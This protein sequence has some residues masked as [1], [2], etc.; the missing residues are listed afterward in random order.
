MKK[1][2]Q[3]DQVLLFALAL[4]L[5]VGGLA[6]SLFPAARFSEKENR[7][8]A[9]FPALTTA[10]LADGSYTAALDTYAAERFPGRLTLRGARALYQ[11]SQGRYEVGGVLLC[12]D[13]S[14]CKRMTVNER[15][16]GQN[17]S[18]LQKLCN[19]YGEKLTIAIAPRRIDARTEVLPALYDQSENSGAWEGLSTALPDAVTFPNLTADAHWYRTDHHWSTAGAYA[20]YCAL[21][22]HLGYT[23]YSKESFTI[24]TVSESFSGTSDAAA[25]IPFIA[26]DHIELYRY[27]GDAD[28]TVRKGKNP[29]PFTGFYD[30]ERLATRDQYSVFLGGNCGVLE[31]TEASD[32]PTLLVIKDS[33]ANALLPFLARHF[34]I[35]AVD[36]RYT[37][38]DIEAYAENAD[39]VLVLCNMQTITESAV[40][41]TLISE[42]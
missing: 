24:E 41:K 23:P 29:A 27:E 4:F 32:R 31:I 38:E 7:N 33:F 21:G 36:P 15:A 10:G 40:F 16:Y 25:G 8:L 42:H 2:H 17:L 1:S 5:G 6:L 30:F 3:W 26:P 11:L 19:R 14:L 39:R 18:A 37:D 12:T 28:F 20:A 13:G 35:V 34:N 22:E 9:E